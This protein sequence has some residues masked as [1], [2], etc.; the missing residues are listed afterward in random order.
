MKLT[1]AHYDKYVLE[2]ENDPWFVSAY[3]AHQTCS[4]RRNR[5][6]TYLADKGNDYHNLD[7]F[8]VEQLRRYFDDRWNIT[9]DLEGQRKYDDL[10]NVWD[11]D[12][13][14]KPVKSKKAAPS[15]T[16]EE[17]IMNS[18]TPIE[19]TTKTFVNGNDVSTM[20]D[21]QIY[22]LIAGEEHRIR[23]LRAIGNQ[24]KRLVAEIAKR[25]AGIQALVTY[26][27][28]KE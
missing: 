9:S 16:K 27:D 10:P 19:I 20:T 12:E 5:I 4:M 26:L 23:E 18:P 2:M 13:P 7:I 24:P 1:K 14:V 28:S 15:S 8:D 22:A 21:G 17:P 11:D 3:K 6:R 25:E